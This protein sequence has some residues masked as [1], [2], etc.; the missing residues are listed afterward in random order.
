MN[1]I[2]VISNG[3]DGDVPLI[4]GLFVVGVFDSEHCG[5]EVWVGW[6]HAGLE[7][8][9]CGA[10]HGCAHVGVAFAGVVEDQACDGVL[11]AELDFIDVEGFGTAV[12][13]YT[14]SNA[15]TVDEDSVWAPGCESIIHLI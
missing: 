5:A 15:A 7:P 8:G 14:A 3:L 6:E 12:V 4:V 2:W 9:S 11:C 13:D 1:T 10:V